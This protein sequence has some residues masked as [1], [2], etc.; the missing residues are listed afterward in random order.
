MSRPENMINVI[1]KLTNGEMIVGKTPTEVIQ[2]IPISGY[3]I[4]YN[5]CQFVL[6][7]N[8]TYLV[9]YH[10]YSNESIMIQN[11]NVVYIYEPSKEVIKTYTDLL[12]GKTKTKR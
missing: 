3:S 8:K 1:M 2:G 11:C 10:I 9:R 12:E 6:T 7:E 4:I 5:P